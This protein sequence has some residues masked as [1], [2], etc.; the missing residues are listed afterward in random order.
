MALYEDFHFYWVVFESNLVP[1]IGKHVFGNLYDVDDSILIYV[2]YSIIY[3][4]LRKSFQRF[5]I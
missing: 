1:V 3:L 2:F 5:I 4:L